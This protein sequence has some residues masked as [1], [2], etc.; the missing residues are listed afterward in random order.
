MDAAVSPTRWAGGKGQDASGSTDSATLEGL[1]AARAT[2]ERLATC[3]LTHGAAA[4]PDGAPRARA[5]AC[6][7]T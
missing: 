6:S 4:T 3:R 5:F 2:V 7:A 1:G